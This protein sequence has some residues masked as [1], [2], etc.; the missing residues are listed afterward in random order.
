M[1]N[2]RDNL[3]GGSS[4]QNS[5]GR[6]DDGRR[7]TDDGTH[8]RGKQGSK[9]GSSFAARF[10][11]IILQN[12]IAALPSAL[13]H[14]QGKLELSAQQ[15]WL[16]SYILSHKWDE[17]LPYPSLKKMAKRTTLSLSQLQRI[18]N[19]LCEMGYLM[20][21]PRFNERLGQGTNA[22]DFAALFDRIETLLSEDPANPNPIRAEVTPPDMVELNELD[23]SFVARYGR[24]IARH[25]VAAVPRAV[26]THQKV[27]GLTA[28]QVW[29]VCYIF[30]F[31]WDTALPYPS[32]RRMSSQTGYS[33]VQLH[34][35]KSE[36]VDAGYLRLVRR[37]N[38]EGG[39]DTNAYDFSGLLEAIRA[40]LQPD[41]GPQ[42]GQTSVQPQEQPTPTPPRRR[43]RH[44]RPATT[45]PDSTQLTRGDSSPLS[46]EASSTLTRGDSTQLA[47]GGSSKFT[48]RGR[49]ELSAQ[50]SA[51][52]TE[53]G[54]AGLA[55]PG[56]RARAG[57]ASSTYARG[58]ARGLHEEETDKVEANDRDD[59]NHLSTK[60]VDE[61]GS[62]ER[63]P[64]PYSPYIAAVITDF[65]DELNDSSHIVSNVTQ[66]LRLWQASGLG[67]QGFT[68]LLYEAKRLTRAYQGK[69][70]LG[71][72]N[73]KMAY[74]FKTVR[75][76][77]R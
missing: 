46:G 77:C 27:L 69:Q 7:T 39:Q 55:K 47:R 45:I 56:K 6:P 60:K 41:P 70:G 23:S 57:G 24:V 48:D 37:I 14:Y 13:Y 12:G 31:Q 58:I 10:G 43:G 62:E 68:E 26:F 72:I 67:E 59:S 50:D 66:A 44:V 40:H 4:Q 75:D 29:F 28:Q 18:K 71:T 38:M 11:R 73:N 17:D 20:V 76:L 49:K 35:I 21:Y 51:Q 74:F 30:S 9:S 33:T 61:N 19:S 36:L 64:P 3:A 25:G 53:A 2:F 34:N 5:I 1:P 15:V 65:S 63:I 54:S 8:G 22:Y 42:G 32:I 52:L 16:V